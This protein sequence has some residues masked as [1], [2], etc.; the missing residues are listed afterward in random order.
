MKLYDII[1]VVFLIL[2]AS[3]GFQRGFFKSLVS[4]LGF[5]IIVVLAYNLKNYLGDFLV[6]NLP[7]IKFNQFLGGGSAVN[8]IMYQTIAFIIVLAILSIIYKIIVTLTGVFE[9]VLKYTI[10]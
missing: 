1:I 7:F 9:K 4:F 3:I 2:C 8:I 6:L 5:I 10:I